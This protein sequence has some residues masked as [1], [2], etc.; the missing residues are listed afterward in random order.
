MNRIKIFLGLLLMVSSLAA[1]VFWETRGRE[2]LLYREVLVAE[3]E[4]KPGDQIS[5]E[6]IS[7]RALPRELLSPDALLP[8][9]E[10][11]V[12]GEVAGQLILS[13]TPISNRYFTAIPVAIREEESV[14]VIP[15]EWISM[16][17]S[18]LRKGDWISLYSQDG[19][20]LIG[21]YQL[22]FVRDQ[23]E[24]E[25]VS[26]DGNKDAPILERRDGSSLI[27]SLEIISSLA[28]YQRIQEA[29]AI[30]GSALMIVQGGGS[31]E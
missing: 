29:M 20:T 24:R 10:S 7:S 27:H 5:S 28:G 25:V 23:A 30:T 31:V 26:L 8:G 1:M 22:A 16:R 18:S 9:Q 4:I 13:G 19:K 6:M 14:F 12:V 21:S 17:S 3:V 2:L 15:S 11:Q